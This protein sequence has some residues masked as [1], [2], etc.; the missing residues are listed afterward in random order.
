[1]E[2]IKKGSSGAATL[3]CQCLLRASGFVGA[4]GKPLALDAKA[5]ENVVS[6]IN[7]FQE[8]MRAYGVECGTNGRNDG[9]FG[10]ACWS[11]MLG[12]DFNE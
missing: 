12:G 4:N 9:Q 6:A 3:A 7:D 10:S 11:A 5:G 1:M 2:C 8:L